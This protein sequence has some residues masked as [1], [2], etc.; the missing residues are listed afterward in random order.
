[1][2]MIRTKGRECKKR[3]RKNKQYTE[4]KWAELITNGKSGD[5]AV[6][7]LDN[8]LDHHKLSKTGK[9]VDKIRRIMCHG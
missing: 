7:E 6:S 3:K 5:L 1:M 8:Y 9:K 2:Q 4:Y